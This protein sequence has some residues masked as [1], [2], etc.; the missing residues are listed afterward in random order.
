MDKEDPRVVEKEEKF[1]GELC[2]IRYD[3]E[4]IG[5]HID[6]LVRKYGTSRT[7]LL[8]IERKYSSKNI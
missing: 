1:Y 2:R 5:T 8:K 7:R 3:D 6:E 4:T